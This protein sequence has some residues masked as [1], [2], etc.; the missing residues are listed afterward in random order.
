MLRSVAVRTI[1][2]DLFDTLVDL[3]FESLPL[4]EVGERRIPSTYR[5]LHDVIVQRVDLDFET[6][7]RE[8]ASVDREGRD[9]VLAEGREYPT[10]ER[11]QALL[12]RLAL[13][14]L[15]LAE[16]LTL[17]HM[18]KLSETARFHP[19]HP[20]VL[21]ELRQTARIG[22]C[23][24]FS[25][26]PTARKLMEEAG[27]LPHIDAAAISEEVGI[28]KPRREIF[29]AALEQLGASH[30]QTVHVGDNL[31]A[32][33]EGAA[34]VGITAVWITRRVRDPAEALRNYKG[35]PPAHIIADLSELP[36]LLAGA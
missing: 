3:V 33:V 14:D 24:N 1:L 2:F 28:R 8:L 17:T 7:A 10:L 13:A 5:A 6:F 31:R 34:A 22:I 9:R 21:C 35:P 19:H 27:L 29:E 12:G 32:D 20:E 36:A 25:H 4:I 23:S 30:E 18:A 26:A 16:T 15:G 11:F